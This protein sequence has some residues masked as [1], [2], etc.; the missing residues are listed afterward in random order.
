MILPT[1]RL[2]LPAVLTLLAVLLAGHAVASASNADHP[3]RT[4]QRLVVRGDATVKDAPCAGGL[5][6]ELTGGTFRGT[7][8][9]TGAYSGRVELK[10]AEAFPNGE[11]GLC[12][13]IRGDIVLGGGTPNRLVLAVAGDSC[14]DGAGNPATSSFTGLAR[15][16]VKYGTGAYAKADGGGIATF[17]EDAA[18]HDGMTLIG[19]ITTR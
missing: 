5:C 18:D 10:L 11:G 8:V 15:F 12:A 7:P 17:L 2:L 19:H 13:P 1:R 4:T 3:K 14:Q 9:G 16:F 6:L